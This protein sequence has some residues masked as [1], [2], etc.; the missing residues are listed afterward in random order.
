MSTKIP[1]K[2][3]GHLLQIKE[4]LD[5]IVF[6]YIDTSQN[7]K[8][9]YLELDSLLDKAA[10]LYSGF[11]EANGD[12]P[13]ENTNAILFLNVSYKLIYFHTISYYHSIETNR[14]A[15]KAQALELLTLAANCIPNV[16]KENHAEYLSE[17]AK[18]Y[19]EISQIQGKKQV[20]EKTIL[21]QNNKIVDCLNSYL[22]ASSLLLK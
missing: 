8:V 10:I 19:E 7:W 17:I 16:Q 2:N 15:V 22:K 12:R 14:E 4:Q 11:K 20:F 18:S 13:R 9:A 1:L 21:E 6:N 3:A 5:E